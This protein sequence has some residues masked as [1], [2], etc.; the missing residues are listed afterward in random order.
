MKSA[1]YIITAVSHYAKKTGL[2][3]YLIGFL[4]V[5]IGTSLPELTTAFM[6]SFSGDNR[7]VIG[8]VIG[9]NIIDVTLVLGLTSIIGKRIKIHGK[10]LDKTVFTVLLM[11]IL[12]LLFGIDGKI[13]RLEGIALILAFFAYIFALL[14][15]EGHFGHIKK[16]ILWKDIWQDMLIVAG[17]LVA[18][19]LSTRWLIIS[20]QK[21]SSIWGISPY[22]VGLVLMAIGTTIPELTVEIS[23]VLKGSTGIAF[24][25]ILGSVVCNSSLVLGLGAVIK[26][27]VFNNRPFISNG[28]FMVTSVFIAI[29]FIKKKEITWEE[30]LGLLLLY[31]TFLLSTEIIL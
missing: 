5:S 19:L 18:L 9:A 14:K 13:N 17:C 25:D 11:S 16:Q 6:A 26:P 23:S 20:A 2:S 7:L 12:P 31:I 22:F 27:I 24:G 8:D 28:L 4:V 1:S 15:K 29:I 10:V 21:I 30:G 3:D